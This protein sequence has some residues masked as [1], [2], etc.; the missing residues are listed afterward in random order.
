MTKTILT[1]AIVALLACPGCG[2]DVATGPEP[3]MSV[4]EVREIYGSEGIEWPNFDGDSRQLIEFKLDGHGST[5]AA[6]EGGK[7]IAA[8]EL[9]S[10]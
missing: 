3:G 6:F 8:K 9:P 1:I 5:M 2:S 7:F 10:I 4:A